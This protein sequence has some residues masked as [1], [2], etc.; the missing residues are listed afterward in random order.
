MSETAPLP[1]DPDRDV[2][3]VFWEAC[4]RREFW[5]QHCSA[6]DAW[7]YYPR[8]MCSHC[9]APASALKWRRPSGAGVLESFTVVHRGSGAFAEYAPY[10]VALVRLAEGPVL[11]TNVVGDGDD[12]AIGAEVQLEFAERAGRTVPVFRP[13]GSDG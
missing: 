11:M 10:V 7:Q 13:G 12:V 3:E 5:L 1:V 2:S 9:W 8:S 6:C 4:E